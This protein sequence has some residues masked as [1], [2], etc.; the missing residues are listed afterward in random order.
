MSQVLT[1]SA[2]QLLREPV[3]AHIAT[4]DGKGRP[5]ISPV[6]VDVEG[7]DVLFN[8]AEGRVKARNLRSNP[9]VAVSVA[10]PADPH[11]VVA[12][13][14]TVTEMTHEGADEHIDFLAN[15]YLGV[16]KFGDRREGQQRVKVRIRPDRIAMQPE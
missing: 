2:K 6:W 14:G 11:R 13:S 15:K 10:D 5:K 12:L 8:T 7:D 16:D 9:N 4:V 1:E 3:L